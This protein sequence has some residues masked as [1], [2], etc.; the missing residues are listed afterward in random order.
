MRHHAGWQSECSNMRGTGHPLD[1]PG[2]A[3]RPTAAGRGHSPAARPRLLLLL[4]LI[5]VLAATPSRADQAGEDPLQCSNLLDA[6]YFARHHR[7]PSAYTRENLVYFLHIP[8]TGGRNFHACF[9]R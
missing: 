1:L 6:A 4:L 2:P 8:R 9:L 3:S 5:D 7:E